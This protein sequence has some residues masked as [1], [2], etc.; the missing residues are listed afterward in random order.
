MPLKNCTVL[1][2]NDSSMDRTIYRS[3]LQQETSFAYTVWEAESTEAALRLCRSQPP[4]SIVLDYLLPDRNGLEFL[5]SLKS[6]IGENCP[7]VIMLNERGNEAI[8][9]Q[10]FKARVEDYL[11]KDEITAESLRYV[12]RTAIKN[13]RWR[14]ELRQ[15]EERYRAMTEQS[16]R[17][18]EN[19]NRQILETL[20]DCVKVLDLEGN[21]QYINAAGKCLLDLDDESCRNANLLNLWQVSSDQQRLQ[22]AIDEAIAGTSSTFQ[23]YCPTSNDTPKWWEVIITP[24]FNVNRQV[25]SLLS[26]SRDITDRRQLEASSQQQLAQ[27]EAIYATAPIGLCFLDPQRRHV[28]I[29]EKLAEIN[30]LSL[31]EHI[32]RTVEEVLPELAATLEPIFEQVLR[33]GIPVL[34]VEIR[35][36]TPAQPKVERYWLANYYPLK[37]AD[38]ESLGINITVQEITERKQAEALVQQQLAQIEA[39]YATA[40]IG[41]CFLDRELRFVQMNER[42]AEI[43]GLSVAEQLG[44]TIWEVL[45]KLAETQQ[46]IFEQV[47]QTGLP[48][49]DVEVQGI[50]PA[51]P[52]VERYWLVSY[53]PLT[54][55]NE[56]VIG[57]NITVLEI[58][59]R[60]QAEKEREQLLADTQATRIA[61]EEA[62]RSKDEF[63]AVIAHELRS[64]I[65]SVAGW[66]Q[67]LRMGKFDQATVDRALE[68]IERGT[69]TQVQLIEDLLDISR[70]AC[71]TLRLTFAPLNLTTVIQA[72]IN[73]V[74]PMA[75]AKQI[76]LETQ[77][78]AIAQIYGDLNRLQ[79]IAVNLLT[80]AIKFTPERGRVT[81]IIELVA[82]QVRIQ[83]K[84]SGKGINPEFLPQIFEQF[85]QGQK[86]SG[87]KD[88]LGLGLAI[89][90]NLVELHHGTITAESPGLGQGATFTV[91]L[92]LHESQPVVIPT[93]IATVT[94]ENPLAGMRILAIDDEPD[95]LE[96]LRF[97]LEN[98]GAEV[99][100]A[101]NG[102]IALDLISQF[103]FELLV[104]DIAMPDLN[105]HELIEQIQT[106]YPE[107]RIRAI[108]LTAYASS[109]DRDY[110]LRIGFEKY[111]SK[112]ID[113]E[114]LITAIVN[115]IHPS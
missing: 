88:G 92:P 74:S 64:P 112:P 4:D 71:G 37:T 91:W 68:A 80:N 25:A 51:Q 114:V 102:A 26:V 58:T 53:Y 70:M 90:K 111:F 32:G 2:V 17:Q 12:T 21:I 42:L 15:R 36:A 38:G 57:I 87:S 23:G 105:G 52:E 45:P 61:A 6:S 84:D 82:Q 110:S 59:D 34:D 94:D 20:P 98:A 89:A 60:K 10:A 77:F 106:L 81:I 11:I 19:F 48:I 18:S 73:L 31:S 46:P 44:R 69:Q 56:Q 49:L 3:Y 109:S 107:R 43:N 93:E 115:L 54:D 108:A 27:L 14:Q 22:Q 79:Q 62:N 33:T 103:D 67:L 30:G 85:R 78:T 13:F 86:N 96:L 75:D 41:L 24:I 76:E 9:I 47:F 72:A 63:V 8:A 16:L 66:A 104:S 101:S 29:N 50:T 113:P 35:G 28:Q 83:V 95:S 7:P 39:I 55:K 5:S 99:Q 65:N 40:P 97:M 1:I 100:T